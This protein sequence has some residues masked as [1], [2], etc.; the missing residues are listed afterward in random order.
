MAT[1]GIQLR[2]GPEHWAQMDVTLSGTVT[3]GEMNKI[4]D[5]VGV[6]FEAGVSGDQ[7]SFVFKAD[8]IVVAKVAGSGLTIA[9]G[10][11]VY[12]KAA[13]DAVTGA[14]SGNTLCGRC[15]VAAG[16]SD[17]TVEISLNG[18]VEA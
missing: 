4:Q 6:Y 8:K 2:C 12:F 17:T 18:D 11:K 7:V 3:A 5:T 15:L 9:Q 10:A 16:A 13:N 1:S 14:S